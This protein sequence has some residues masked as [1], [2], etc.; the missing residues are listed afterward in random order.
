MKN[1]ASHTKPF[2]SIIIAT[3]NCYEQLKRCVAS[4][5][6]Q[7]FLDYEVLISDG[8]SVD[9][10]ANLIGNAYVRNLTWSK[11]SCDDGIYD[12]L[13]AALLEAKGEWVLVIG[14]DDKL[15]DKT[16]LSDAYEEIKK[17]TMF[18]EYGLLYSNIFI[19]NGDEITLK[20]FPQFSEFEKLYW[21]GG[22]VHHQSA[23]VSRKTIEN[24]PFFNKQYRVH[25]DHDLMLSVISRH[26]CRKIEGAFVVY[27][28]DGFSSRLKNLARSFIEVAQIRMRHGYFPMP[29]RLI[30]IYVALLARTLR[31]HLKGF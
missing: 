11:S 29:P 23:F 2:F 4:I 18:N 24:Y 20:R 14:A 26:G 28:S 10:T 31:R 21:G 30:A 15:V 8:G 17:V 25:A 12:A 7:Q 5:N 6:N 13:N 3:Y 22:F 19:D 27:R 1:G 16:A 9:G